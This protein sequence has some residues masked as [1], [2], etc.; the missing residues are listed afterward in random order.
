MS[1]AEYSC[2]LFKPI[3]AY[4]QTVWTQIRLLL[5]EQSDLGPHC[6]QQW[7]LSNR[8]KTKQTTIVVIG[9]LRVNI[10]TTLFLTTRTCPKMW[11]HPFNYLLMCQK[12]VGWVAN[13]ADP[14]QTCLSAVSDMGLCC[15]LKCVCQTTLGKYDQI[16]SLKLRYLFQLKSIVI[17]FYFSMKWY[18]LQPLYNTVCYN[19]VL[20]ITWFKDGSQKCIDYIE[21]WP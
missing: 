6:L 11:S 10:W 20:D 21:K 18:T 12:N 8:Q 15:L 16:W 9:A 5:K 13:S 4:R 19:T 3:F 14:D 17:F 1:S 7:L 2:R